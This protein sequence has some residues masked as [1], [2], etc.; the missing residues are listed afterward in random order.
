MRWVIQ[1]LINIILQQ[2]NNKISIKSQIVRQ[3][4]GVLL[5]DKACT[6]AYVYSLNF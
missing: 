5:P 2:N 3:P 4:K 1:S 6:M